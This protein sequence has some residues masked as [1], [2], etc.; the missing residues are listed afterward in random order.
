LTIDK[1]RIIKT[2]KRF[3]GDFEKGFEYFN[4]MTKQKKQKNRNK[5]KIWE[6]PGD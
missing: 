5:T 3:K 6:K 1:R 4:F 2:T